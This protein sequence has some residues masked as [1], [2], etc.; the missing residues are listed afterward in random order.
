VETFI[1]LNSTVK[2]YLELFDPL[3]KVKQASYTEAVK[4]HGYI[5]F[6]KSSV[7]LKKIGKFEK[8]LQTLIDNKRIDQVFDKY[9][10]NSP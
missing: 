8:A 7:W 9:K 10:V 1:H 4:T 2:P 3:K 6:S 5:A